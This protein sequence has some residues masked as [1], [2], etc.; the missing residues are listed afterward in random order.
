MSTGLTASPQPAERYVR[1][2]R[3]HRVPLAESPKGELSCP[4]G[5]APLG[6]YVVDR[7]RG[8]VISESEIEKGEVAMMR[9]PLLSPEAQGYPTGRPTK[10][11]LERAKFQHGERVLWI[12]LRAKSA[13]KG[14]DPF[15]VEWKLLEGAGKNVERSQGISITVATEADARKEYSKALEE[16]RTLGWKEVP[17]VRGG[18]RLVLKPIP[19]PGRG[20]RANA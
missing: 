9:K 2:C 17:V 14:A 20:R 8:H 4:R 18:T 7:Q 12:R 11:V 6:W 15:R 10:G 13:G 1:Y 5:H 16:T 19:G 3:S